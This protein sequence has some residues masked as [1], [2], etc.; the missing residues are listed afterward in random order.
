[1]PLHEK[2]KDDFS[3]R[4]LSAYSFIQDV[5]LR[6]LN[7]FCWISSWIDPLINTLIWQHKRHSIM[8]KADFLTW[9]SGEYDITWKPFF[10]PIQTA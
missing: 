1:M 3:P 6:F 4:I 7:D 10:Y 2:M 8:N 9:L 5:C